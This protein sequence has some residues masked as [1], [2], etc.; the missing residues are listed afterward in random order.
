MFYNRPVRIIFSLN[1]NIEHQ[2]G[3]GRVLDRGTY[4]WKNANVSQGDLG[5]QS[6]VTLFNGLQ[7]LNNMKMNKANYQM[8]SEDLEAMV[9]NI[10]IQVMTGYLDLLRNQELADVL[11]TDASD[12]P[13][14]CH[15]L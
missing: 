8:S 15:H 13:Q 11:F 10:T 3:A 14:R 12:A 4:T 7:G 9:D 5:V 2:L 1:G 6:D